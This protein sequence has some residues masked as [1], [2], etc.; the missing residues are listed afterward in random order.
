VSDAAALDRVR[1]LLGPLAQPDAPLG[2]RTTYRVGGPAAVLVEATSLQDLLAVHHA[3]ADVHEPVPF[4]VV[5]Q[6]SNLLVADQGFPG[7]AVVLGGELGWVGIPTGADERAS[8][9][10]GRCGAGSDGAGP[11][12]AAVLVRAGGAARLPVV[13]R[14][15]A[16]AG[17]RG[18]EWAVGVPGSVGGAVRMNAG[19]HGADM[20]A[21]LHRCTTLDMA[22]GRLEE[23]TP[24]E[25]ALGYR[26]S[27]LGPG[28]VVVAADLLARRGSRDE[29]QRAVADIVRWRRQHQPGGA[30]AGSVF[31]NPPGDAAGRLVERAGL[32]GRR[33]GTAQVSAKHANFIQADAGGRAAD[34]RALIELV[35]TEVQQCSGVTLVPEV[36]LVGFPDQ[37]LPEVVGV[38]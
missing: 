35:I 31:T 6:G 15:S 29:A 1:R 23:R 26:S 21:V 9:P 10:T 28:E 18:L 38:A 20:A 19:G 4:I 7:V 32:K 12:G 22:T 13:A 11:D 34:V 27:A 14:Q 37:P 5:G 30:N 2:A 25:L 3:L 16:S 8:G 24:D 17:L 36:R 33:L